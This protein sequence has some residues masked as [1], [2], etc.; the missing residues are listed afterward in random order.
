[1]SILRINNSRDF[2][3]ISYLWLWRKVALALLALSTNA[4]SQNPI[5]IS[6]VAWNQLSVGE[7]ALIQKKYVV[8]LVE[9]DAFGVIIDNQGV[10][11]SSAG[12][13]GG[14]YLGGAVA[15]AAYIDNAIKGGN[16]SAKNQLASGILGALLG[17]SL[18]SKPNSQY[19][20]RY[21]VKLGDG[22]I[23]YFD[24]IKRD[25]FRHPVG[26]CV[27]VPNI[28]PIDQK[29]CGQTGESLRSVYLGTPINPVVNALPILS[30]GT[31]AK[32]QKENS[33][34]QHGDSAQTKIQCKLGTLAPV[35]TSAEKCALI[36]GSQV[37]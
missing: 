30:P 11:E 27:S 14:A 22:N 9:H 3:L 18:D 2:Q 13:N 19:H 20:Y 29:L 28:A 6:Q 17:S 25:P 5:R 35:T 37:Q 12:T 33:V 8:E 31:D 34:I 1:M 36:K 32:P 15:N 4:F 21:A 16:Y 10:D 23:K 24:E 26:I 7:H